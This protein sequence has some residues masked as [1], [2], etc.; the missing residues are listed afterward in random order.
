M[1][2]AL[3]QSQID[4]LLNK[5]KEG[6][7]ATDGPA[8]VKDTAKLYDFSSPR[9]FTKDQL[10]SL[11]T[12][13]ENYARILAVYLTG[14]LSDVCTVEV[15]GMEEQR[16]YEFNNSI[17]DSTLVAL[18]TF[19][20]EIK[21][22]APS[23][24]ILQIPTSYGYLLIDRLLGGLGP[25]ITPDRE[26]T[27]IELTLLSVVINNMVSYI[28]E[29]WSNF[30]PLK[31]T[32]QSVE[33]NGRLLQAYSQQDIVVITSLEIKDIHHTGII[34][35]CMPATN[36]DDV[37]SSFG[38]RYTQAVRLADSQREQMRHDLIMGHI[39]QSDLQVEAI[40]DECPMNLNDLIY[41]QI[42]DVITLNT[43]MYNDIDVKVA[44]IPWCTARIGEFEEN[45]AIKI[46]DILHE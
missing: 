11:N 40:L 39:R 21:E 44:G 31:V 16:Y 13:Y 33:T 10:N 2:E 14:V 27:E 28:E 5:M 6:T 20:P 1:A 45:K 26:Y 42:G 30:F 32:L 23:T 8:E 19:E 43:K 38:A 41:L 12:L 7:P 36:L 9:K 34:N 46:V 4:E 24:L 17:P 15:D 29:S 18:I 22:C 37:I 35:I 25:A 3:S